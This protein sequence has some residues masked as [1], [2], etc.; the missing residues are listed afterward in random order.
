ME[1]GKELSIEED[2]RTRRVKPKEFIPFK[3]EEGKIWLRHCGECTPPTKAVRKKFPEAE[4]TGS[5]CV[6]CEKKLYQKLEEIKQ[7]E[8]HG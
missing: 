8:K 4:F 7:V 5:F 6:K 3:D 1:E 2:P